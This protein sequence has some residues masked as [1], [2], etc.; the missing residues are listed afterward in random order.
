MKTPQT[1]QS[2]Q[3]ELR[4]AII[5][6]KR[7]MDKK[8]KPFI[9]Q[10]HWNYQKKHQK[11]INRL[12]RIRRATPEAKRKERDY[13][14]KRVA[15]KRL[16]DRKRYMAL[17]PKILDNIRRW[18]IK[19]RHKFES[20]HRNYRAIKK[21]ARVIG[22]RLIAGFIKRI[23]SIPSLRCYYCQNVVSKFHLDH[24]VPLSRNGAHSLDNICVACVS[25]NCSKSD[26]LISE[27]IIS[28][29]LLLNL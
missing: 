12:A 2:R 17:K 8:G 19:N 24:I 22:T 13:A 25:C 26:K 28:G 1:V 3:R 6:R 10:Y 15:L 7:W 18:Q 29:Q 23:K 16:Y 11:R 4:M 27:W 9:R 5:R 20:Y 21:G 14:K